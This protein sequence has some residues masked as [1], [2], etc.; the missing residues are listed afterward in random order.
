MVTDHTTIGRA[1]N[2]QSQWTRSETFISRFSALVKRSISKDDIDL[3]II[4]FRKLKLGRQFSTWLSD[5][6]FPGGDVHTCALQTSVVDMHRSNRSKRSFLKRSDQ[7]SLVFAWLLFNPLTYKTGVYVSRVMLNF[8]IEL[9][10][11]V[12]CSKWIIPGSREANWC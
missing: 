5:R 9:D 8:L 2:D 7:T 12:A 3:K 6:E 10:K 1:L 11:M 4:R